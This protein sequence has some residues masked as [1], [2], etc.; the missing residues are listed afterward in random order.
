MLDVT[1]N[2][3]RSCRQWG[4][5]QERLTVD[6]AIRSRY[7]AVALRREALS[8]S[9][10]EGLKASPRS[11][12]TAIADG[13]ATMMDKADRSAFANHEFLRI[14]LDG[15][16]DGLVDRIAIAHTEWRKIVGGRRPDITLNGYRH[17]VDTVMRAADGGNPL[18]FAD[19]T[20]QIWT[21]TA[22]GN[23]ARRFAILSVPLTTRLTSGI[24]IGISPVLAARP[25]EAAEQVGHDDAK[26]WRSFFL[27]LFVEATRSS[28]DL[29]SQ[30]E[31]ERQNLELAVTDR[32]S[33]S[34]TS[35]LIDLALRKPSLTYA[36]VASELGT[37]FRGAQ[38]IA[39]KLVASGILIKGEERSRST[40]FHLRSSIS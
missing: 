16:E 26:A 13:T 15:Q 12:W 31:R 35:A 40:L 6:P 27:D 33:T 8:M 10:S 20:K 19:M 17:F 22:L 23:D 28:L 18:R 32:R 7:E 38:M 25:R 34:R 39:D 3:A 9:A 4:T 14:V 36:L 37:T 11:L 5:L 21:D 1:D 29:S 2:I 30:I 24:W